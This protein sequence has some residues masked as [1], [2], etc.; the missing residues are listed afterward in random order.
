[1]H[2][3]DCWE[4]MLRYV[5]QFNGSL[6]VWVGSVHRKSTVCN[7]RATQFDLEGEIQKIWVW[8]ESLGDG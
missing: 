2:H 3:I 1:M 4:L 5:G 6:V 7:G 8:S